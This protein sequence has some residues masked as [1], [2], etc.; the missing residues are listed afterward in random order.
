M[1]DKES[2][3][4]LEALYRR[5]RLMCLGYLVLAVLALVFFFVDRRGMVAA[6][7]G[8]LVFHLLVIRPQTAAYRRSYIHACAM[9]MLSRRF[10]APIHQPESFFAPEELRKVRLIAANSTN[11]GVLCREGCLGTYRGMEV[12]LGDITLAHSYPDGRGLRHQFLTGTWVTVKLG[13]DTGLDWRL[14]REDLMWKGSSDKLYKENPDLE[15]LRDLGPKW[16][17]E[18]WLTVRRKGTP[19][20]PPDRVMEA[21]KPLA[22]AARMPM[23]VCI[24]GD[25]MHFFLENVILAMKVGLRMPPQRV[26]VE[27]DRIPELDRFLAV[28]WAT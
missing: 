10:Q 11:G 28:A 3:S 12:L 27:A 21:L 26:L 9:S 8:C 20:F 6:L 16:I 15:Q 19:D 22:R 23:A 4:A 24:Q 2:F 18:G 17:R 25:Q 7:A 14:I 13:K 1:T 5:L